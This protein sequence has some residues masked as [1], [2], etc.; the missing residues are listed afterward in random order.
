[1]NKIN[2][3]FAQIIEEFYAEIWKQGENVLTGIFTQNKTWG[4]GE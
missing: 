3:F 4:V 2:Y 1:M